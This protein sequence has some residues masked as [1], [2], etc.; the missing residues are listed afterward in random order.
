MQIRRVDLLKIARKHHFDALPC[1]Y[2]NR[3]DFIGR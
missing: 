1:S 3:F 2:D